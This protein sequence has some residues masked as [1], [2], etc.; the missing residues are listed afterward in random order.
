LGK[1]Y[2]EMVVSG[3]LAAYY[4]VPGSALDEAVLVAPAHTFLAENRPVSYQFWLAA[5]ASTWGRRLYQP[6]THPYVLSRS[7]PDGQPWS[8]EDELRS[9]AD[10]LRRLVLG[11]L[12]RCRTS[13]YLVSSE[14]NVRGQEERGPLLAWIQ[15][16]AR[17]LQDK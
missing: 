15:R 8:E 5:D 13:V 3:V 1:K 14:L 4:P 7:W 6:L 17:E 10:N 12:R 2:Y 16:L 9:S 11:L